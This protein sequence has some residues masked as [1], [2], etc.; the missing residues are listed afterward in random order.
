M[1]PVQSIAEKIASKALTSLIIAKKSVKQAMNMTLN[2]GL[3]FEKDVF[4]SMLNTKAA[5]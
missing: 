2:Q 1:L 4:Y 5:K 3:E